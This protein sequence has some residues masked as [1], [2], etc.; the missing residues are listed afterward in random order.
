MC[1]ALEWKSFVWKQSQLFKNIYHFDIEDAGHYAKGSPKKYM[2]PE[3]KI[4]L[5]ESVMKWHVKWRS[6]SLNIRGTEINTV[7]TEMVKYT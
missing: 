7:A 4:N 3:N 6:C 2:N 5:E 1:V